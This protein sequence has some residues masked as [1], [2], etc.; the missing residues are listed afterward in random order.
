[1]PLL[2]LIG[3]KI[4]NLITDGILSRAKGKKNTKLDEQC[5]KNYKAMNTKIDG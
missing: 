4:R 2:I 5:E 1:M 3:I